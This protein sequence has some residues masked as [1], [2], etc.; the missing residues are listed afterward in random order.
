VFRV[1]FDERPGKWKINLEGL[2]LIF[3]VGR[4]LVQVGINYNDFDDFLAIDYNFLL[5]LD[6]LLCAILG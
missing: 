2:K 6:R 4:G 5:D 1:S 3:V